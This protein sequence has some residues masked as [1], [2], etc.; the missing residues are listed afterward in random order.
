[1]NGLYWGMYH[2]IERIEDDFFESHFGGDADDYDANKDLSGG[3]AVEII[4]GDN[5]DWLNVI[6]IANAGVATE[7]GY[8]QLKAEID[9][10]NMIDYLM[11]NFFI[12]NDDWDH[13]NWRTGTLQGPDG[14]FRFFSWDA[15]RSD[16]N[17]LSGIN[18]GVN[19]DIQNLNRPNRSSRVHQQLRANPEY[20]LRWADRVHVNCFNGGPLTPEKVIERYHERADQIRLALVAESARWGDRHNPVTPMTPDVPWEGNLINMTSNFFPLRT[21]VMVSQYRSSGLYPN[22]D[23][24]EFNRHGGLFTN[25]FQLVI[26]GPTNIYYT[27]DGSD[28]REYLT[29]SVLGTAYAGPITLTHDVRVKARSFDGVEWSALTDAFFTEISP[30]ALHLSELMYHPRD[31]TPAEALAGYTA[32]YFEFIE[33]C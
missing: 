11:M 18:Q 20:R 5:A 19:A 15:E 3:T 29:G 9:I 4:D 26:N 28:P 32:S 7:A 12:L 27:V 30:P 8:A 14:R 24:P 1:I 6:A 31:P 13:N 16:I 33:F 22:L 2:T 25:G 23:A 10:D 21:G 17:A